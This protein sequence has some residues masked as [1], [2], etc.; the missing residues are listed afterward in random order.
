MEYMLKRIHRDGIDAALQKADKYRELSQPME[1]ASIC[2]DV[3]AVDADNQLAQRILGLAL[4][5]QFGAS[6]DALFVEA[7]RVFSR[8]YDPYERA[9]YTGIAYERRAKAQLAASIPLYSVRPLF[10]QALARYT[11]AEALRPTGNDDP[12]LRWNSCVRALQAAPGFATVREHEVK[13][14]WEA[15]SAPHHR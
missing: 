3:L 11:E 14:D 15:D 7:E 6:S 13:G 2:R 1:A 8:L 10:E 12:V 9:F 4:T 5:D